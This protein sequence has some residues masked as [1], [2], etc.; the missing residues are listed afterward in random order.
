MTSIA[1]DVIKDVIVVSTLFLL[2]F[3]FLSYCALG[4]TFISIITRSDTY[5]LAIGKG[6]SMYPT[7]RDGDYIIVDVT[8]ERI[9]LGDVIV[10]IH[11]NEFICHRVI[12]ITKEGYILKGDNNPIPDP[13]I[14]KREQILG[15]VEW[16]IR[17]PLYK[18]IAKMWFERKVEISG[19][20][21]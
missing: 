10:Y 5:I 17:D 15:E 9:E 13:W 21:N 12:A 2:I 20:K 7:I 18:E 4:P 11:G 8:P 14:V 6:M 3:L 1:K 19:V 16:I